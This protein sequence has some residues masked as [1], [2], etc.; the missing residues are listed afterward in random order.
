M[1]LISQL[2]PRIRCVHLDHRRG[3]HLVRPAGVCAEFGA[4]REP[5]TPKPAP[6]IDWEGRRRL[7]LLGTV[8]WWLVG[9][10]FFAMLLWAW[11]S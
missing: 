8:V 4:G 11:L 3:S 1:R 6:V 7:A 9:G 10:L 5:R 2:N